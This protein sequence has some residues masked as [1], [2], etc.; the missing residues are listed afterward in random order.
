MWEG[1]KEGRGKQRGNLWI[2]R[3]LNIQ[4]KRGHVSTVDTRQCL[5]D[6][7]DFCWWWY[8]GYFEKKVHMED[9]YEV[10]IDIII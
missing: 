10:F 9:T 2:K 1:R 7:T 5:E 4:E 3:D 6:I 8:S